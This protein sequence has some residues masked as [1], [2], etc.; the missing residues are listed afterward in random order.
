MGKKIRNHLK[1]VAI[2]SSE[3]FDAFLF[4]DLGPDIKLNFPAPLRLPKTPQQAFNQDTKKIAA[5]FKKAYESLNV[6]QAK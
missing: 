2:S 6:I 3:F 4:G 1:K 5:D